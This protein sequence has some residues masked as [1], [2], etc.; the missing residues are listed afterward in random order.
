MLLRWL[1]ALLFKTKFEL[2]FR[3]VTECKILSNPDLETQSSDGKVAGFLY[4]H[5]P[6]GRFYDIGNDLARCITCPHTHTHTHTQIVP[7]L[8]VQRILRFTQYFS[9][10]LEVLFCNYF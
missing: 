8:D 2:C 9:I 1:A 6:A 10:T 4:L 7:S 5:T 3:Q